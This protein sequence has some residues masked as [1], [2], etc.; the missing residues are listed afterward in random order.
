MTVVMLG[1]GDTR[2]AASA[3]HLDRWLL[4]AWAALF[5]NV[6]PFSS[7]LALIPFPDL[8]GKLIS[9]GALPLALLFALLAN[10][11]GLLRPNVYVVL[12]AVLCT[13]AL[14]VS[15][16]N[17]FMLSSTFRAARFA[18]FMLVL[19]L[20]S[21]F[22]GRRDLALLRC[23]RNCLAVI[24]ASVFVGAVVSPGRAFSFEGRLAGVIWP[25]FPTEVAHYASVLM[26]ITVLLWMCRVVP[27]RHAAPILALTVP[28]LVA[29]HTRT[30]LVGGAVALVLASASLLLARSRARRTWMWGVLVAPTVL[31]VFTSELVSWFLRGQT[32]NE[33]AGLTGR[34]SVWSAVLSQPRPTTQ[35]VFGSG[36]S[37]LSYN[38]L[39]IDS[40]WVG[41][42]L[43]LG[44]VG[45]A[46]EAVLLIILLVTALLRPSGPGPAVAIFLVVYTIF[47]S[48]TQTGMSGPTGTLLDLAVASAALTRSRGSEI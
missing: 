3:P 26:G 35:E 23:H 37:N 38:G 42:Y 32:S 13:L 9:Q 41:T 19:W 12:F 14:M 28:V 20:L 48:I 45:V 34:T 1:R 40:N 30:A 6:M 5:L 10:P 17:T 21:P 29:T 18:G 46:I 36:M 11:R 24:I 39:P 16:H 43:D 47:S 31:A 7:A 22:W 33:A 44:L 15:P 2:R 25:I 8:M 4:L 27:G